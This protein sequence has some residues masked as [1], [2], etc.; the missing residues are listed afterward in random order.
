[1]TFFL[2]MTV[3]PE[4][5]KRA[6]EELERV[7]GRDRLPLNSDLPKLPYIEAIMKET[8]RWHNVVPMGCKLSSSFVISRIQ[9]LP[10]DPPRWSTLD[11]AH[12]LDPASIRA[13]VRLIHEH[14][15]SLQYSRGCLPGL[16][17]P[18]G[19]SSTLQHMVCQIAWTNFS[20]C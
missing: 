13:Q 1:M 4:V 10:P 19:S 12:N 15:A 16:P 17:N 3:F 5:Q 14:S 9:T 18:E 2:A 7:V 8:H 11:L 6:Q 20:L